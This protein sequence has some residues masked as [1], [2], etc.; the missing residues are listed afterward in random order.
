[1]L[2]RN[3]SNEKERSS[4]TSLFL[5]L[6]KS[7]SIEEV[8]EDLTE[9]AA[10]KGIHLYSVRVKRGRLEREFK[11]P[12][13]VA[14]AGRISELAVGVEGGQPCLVVKFFEPMDGAVVC[15]IEY[16]AHLAAHRIEIL[17]GI[18]GRPDRALTGHED[19]PVVID[20]LIGESEL[21][22]EVRRNIV[23]A[24]SLDLSVLITGE[25][26]SR[27]QS[28]R[29]RCQRRRRSK[30]SPRLA[31]K[32]DHPRRRRH[33]RHASSRRILRGRQIARALNRSQRC[34]PQCCARYGAGSCAAVLI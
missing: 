18:G 8:L 27:G 25:P 26:R 34:R 29:G 13:T 28:R 23:I 20:E 15:E 16:A 9:I 14:I 31:G 1:M 22:R 19:H 12:N 30:L 5:R 17:A 32:Q 11:P 21:M 2:S 10:E 24:A 3:F 6:A 33:G 7:A 4:G